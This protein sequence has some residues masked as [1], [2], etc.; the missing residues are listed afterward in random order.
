MR[1][2][3][4]D[5]KQWNVLAGA[6]TATMHQN[7]RGMHI[8]YKRLF[9]TA[10]ATLFLQSFCASNHACHARFFLL[11]HRPLSLDHEISVE[12]HDERQDYFESLIKTNFLCKERGSVNL[13][14]SQF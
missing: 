13:G 10:T 11:V 7:S 6:A 14:D 4:L 9:M 2:G 8:L 3:R 1:G 12:P 5:E